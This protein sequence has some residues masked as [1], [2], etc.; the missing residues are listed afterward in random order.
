MG[1]PTITSATPAYRRVMDAAGQDLYCSSEADWHS[2]LERL[3][4]HED[5]RRQAGTSGREFAEAEYSDDRLLAKW[6]RV[7]ES[8]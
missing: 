7:L 4:Q 8:L 5:A 6:D 2:T 3:I 1:L